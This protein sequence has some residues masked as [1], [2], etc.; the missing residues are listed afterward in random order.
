MLEEL[1]KNTRLGINIGL[2]DEYKH[3]VKYKINDFLDLDYYWK[4]RMKKDAAGNNT[5]H[6]I[7]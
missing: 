5:M 4:S 6:L 3:H 2:S 7:W 1:V